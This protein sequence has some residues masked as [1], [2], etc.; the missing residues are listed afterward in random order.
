MRKPSFLLPGLLFLCPAPATFAGSVINTNLPSNVEIVNILGTADGASGNNPGIGEFSSPYSTDPTLTL[1]AGTYEFFLV[2]P[3]DAAAAF[4]S[5]SATQLGTIQTAWTFNSPWTTDY[6]VFDGSAVTDPSKTQLFDGA[7]GTYNEGTTYGSQQA[8]Y[9]AARSQDYYD[10]IRV[11]DRTSLN[12]QKT[13][14]LTS[15]ETLVFAIPDYYLGDNAGGVSVVVE[16]VPEPKTAALCLAGGAL[17]VLAWKR[18]R[19]PRPS[20]E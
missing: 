4:P 8:A 18:R 6:V 2:D 3:A 14:T 9:D 10:N 16:A 11:G 20:V 1:A 7:N 13:Y 15:A 19:K 17:G 5:L 12:F